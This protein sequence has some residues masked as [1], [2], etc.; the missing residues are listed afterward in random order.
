MN[1]IDGHIDLYLLGKDYLAYEFLGSKLN[2]D[3][4]GRIISTTFTVYAPNAKEVRLLSSFNNYEGWKH[5]LTKVH[6]QGFFSI[7]IPE[8]LEWATYR[9]ELHLN[10]G[11]IIYKSDPFA[12]YAEERPNNASK[13][14]DIDGYTWHDQKWFET[15]KKVYQEPFLIYEL[16]LGSWK[17][18]DGNFIRYNEIVD[19]LIN[20]VKE[21]G[22]THIELMPIYEH[23]LDD[24]WGYQGTGFF[25]ATS[26]Y[27][28]PKDLMYFIDRCHEAGIGVII[29][30]V[31][32]HINKDWFG[33]SKFDGTYLYE[34]EDD[35]RREN[36]VWGTSNI[37]F[38]KGISR[39]FMQSA[40]NFWVDYFHVDGFRI[41]AV[42]NLIYHLGNRDMG[43]NTGAL[44]FLRQVSNHL[45][46]KDD[47]I[48]FSAEDSTDYARVTWPTDIG[49]VGFNYK[50]NMGFMNDTLK[51][52]KEDPIY[53]KYHHDKITFGL[54]YTYNEQFIL[55]F[56]HDEVVHLK[57]S[58]LN[59]MPGTYEQKFQ[60]YRLLLTLWMTH[61]GKKLLF[62][63]QEFA[64]Y[65]EWNFKQEL[66]WG[67]LNY[68]IHDSANRYFKDLAKIYRTNDALYKYDHQPKGFVWLASDHVDS[69]VFAYMR[70]SDNETLVIVLNMTPNYY[71][72]YEIPVPFEGQYEE[73]LNSDKDIYAGYGQ[74]NGLP[75][76]AINEPRGHF[77]YHL[78]I[79]LGS[80]T[81]LI[82]RLKK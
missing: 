33:L 78:K 1:K 25:A 19:D 12:Y 8:N 79:K 3:K 70:Q 24:S 53:R 32:G 9:Y 4:D 57:G 66:D 61:P 55:P 16:H 10:S 45:F 21:N 44:S 64:Q 74:Y 37:D 65:D 34:F 82:L 49:G 52:F 15:K 30:W 63:G 60:N 28:T 38:D 51:Y 69:S 77:N 5:V 23:P 81:G 73:I 75:L 43:E 22:F 7:T 48:I 35:L 46:S 6:P 13:V 58:L 40:L 80:L 54:V 27:G 36:V 68:P 50:W 29:D 2:K 47:R 41:D 42:S 11:E 71:E 76:K 62:M 17:K 67:L 14:Y 39:S 31:L 72:S 59:K 20:Y 18:K 26:R 56:S